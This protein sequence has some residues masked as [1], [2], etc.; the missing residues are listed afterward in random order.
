VFNVTKLS[1]PV[2][3]SHFTETEAS[4]ITNLAV[5]E[6][7][8]Y[9]SDFHQGFRI[10]EISDSIYLSEIGNNEVGG[11]PLGFQKLIPVQ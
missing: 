6:G 5:F 8:L 3:V 10:F 11:S 9:A 1:D 2:V 7:F 4:F